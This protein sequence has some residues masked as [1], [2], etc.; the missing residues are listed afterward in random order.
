MTAQLQQAI[1]LLKISRKELGDTIRDE[2]LKN[3]ILEDAVDT[4]SE[5]GKA[6]EAV[7][8]LS[9]MEPDT[10][11]AEIERALPGFAEYYGSVEN[12]HDSGTLCAVFSACCDFV[13]ER[14]I[15][16]ECWPRLAIVVNAAATDEAASGAAR[17]CFLENLADPSHPLKRFLTG[18]ALSYWAAWE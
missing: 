15:A 7:G 4:A 18:E 16:A 3:P 8:A 17:T 5:E 12:L 9:R 2:I 14:P 11:I 6:A 10:L 1:E 13:R